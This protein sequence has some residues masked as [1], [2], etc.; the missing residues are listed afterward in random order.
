[1]CHLKRIQ[2]D[3]LP[4]FRPNPWVKGFYESWTL[5]DY[6]SAWVIYTTIPMQYTQQNLFAL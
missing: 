6:C 4:V 3:A 1:M 5:A 2:G